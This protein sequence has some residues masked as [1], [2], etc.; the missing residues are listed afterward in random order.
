MAEIENVPFPAPTLT[1]PIPDM[2]RTLFIVPDDVAPVVFPDADRDTV[3]KFV[4]EGVVAE[5]V[6]LPAPAP[7]LTIPAPDMLSRFENVPDALP[8]VF[9]RAVRD[10]EEVCTEADTVMV[11]LACPIPIPAPAEI[12]NA[13]LEALRDDTFIVALDDP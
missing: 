9:P 4:T 12:D 5:I 11:E 10:T 3:E 1:I 6:I 13:P 7:T 8:V 2:A